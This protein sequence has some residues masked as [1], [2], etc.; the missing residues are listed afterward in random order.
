[1]SE[2]PVNVSKAIKCDF[3][4][5]LAAA[6]FALTVNSKSLQ[7]DV[8]IVVLTVVSQLGV[9]D[10]DLVGRML[11]ALFNVD[12][13]FFNLFVDSLMGFDDVT[14]KDARIAEYIL[15]IGAKKSYLI[16]GHKV[17]YQVTMSLTKFFE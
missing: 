3:R 4:R 13:H 15:T 1:M 17:P 2:V 6:D 10:F 9:Y 16:N 8:L 14:D 11:D 5:L 7:N 12:G